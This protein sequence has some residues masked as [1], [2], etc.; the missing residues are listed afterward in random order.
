M[1][2]ASTRADGSAPDGADGVGDRSSTALAEGSG[3][4][5]SAATEPETPVNTRGARRARLVLFAVCAL[6]LVL[7]TR[8]APV[9]GRDA[10]HLATAQALVNHG[11]LEIGQS[12]DRFTPERVRIGGDAGTADEGRWY[13]SVPALPSIVAAGALWSGGGYR[14]ATLLTAS[15]PTLLLLA[16][17]ARMLRRLDTVSSGR[18][19]ILVVVAAA[20]PVLGYGTALNGMPLALLGCALGLLAHLERRPWICGAALGLAIAAE[21]AA[22][23]FALCLVP[24][25]RR[26]LVRF[27]AG[28]ALLL[29]VHLAARIG[30]GGGPFGWP[31]A[32]W[33]YALSFADLAALA[34]GTDPFTGGFADAWVGPRGL[35]TR[36]PILVLGAVGLFDALRRQAPDSRRLVLGA[37]LLLLAGSLPR[38]HTFGMIAPAH[39]LLVV[40]LVFG[41]ARLRLRRAPS[42]TVLVAALALLSLPNTVWALRSPLYTWHLTPRHVEAAR[43]GLDDPA[44][45]AEN[46]WLAEWER[47]TLPRR[48][49]REG[50]SGEFEGRVELYARAV[51]EPTAPKEREVVKLLN[52]LRTIAGRLDDEG[53]PLYT[54]PFVHYWIGRALEARG[55]PALAEA[56]Y[57][58]C[59][60]LFPSFLAARERVEALRL[61]GE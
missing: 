12:P 25:E 56:A 55:E 47:A 14:A 35:V 13:A 7:C 3:D 22:A 27:V 46:H 21:P 50:L 57:R 23:A 41:A 44:A 19:T 32:A 10:A 5:A 37:L 59:L 15:L 2:S 39:L 33:A 60:H 1:T 26:T 49:G 16:I 8:P 40:P 6:F 24:L 45:R 28:A 38:H 20:T 43:L 51:L 61:R 18:T 34:P 42:I 4:D 36:A 30:A 52:G 53:S 48:S 31:E 11:T 17:L 29:G 58:E 9:D 54:R